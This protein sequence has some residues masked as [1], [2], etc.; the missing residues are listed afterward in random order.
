VRNPQGAWILRS[1][2]TGL[3]E[4]VTDT[5]TC[6]HGNEICEIPPGTEPKWFC[7]ICGGFLCEPCYGEY[8][9]RGCVPYIKKVEEAEERFYRRRQFCKMVGV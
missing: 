5:I 7:P 9:Q 2:E 3:E 1:L 8:V 6:G 4:S